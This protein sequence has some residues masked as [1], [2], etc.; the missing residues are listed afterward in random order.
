MASLSTPPETLAAAE[1]EEEEAGEAEE[2]EE[3]E[4]PRIG[5]LRSYA[6]NHTVDETIDLLTS[7]IGG[8]NFKPIVI[9]ESMC[10]SAP[11]VM[12][13]ILGEALFSVEDGKLSEQ[14][15]TKGGAY[16]KA[17]C[18]D[19]VDRQLATMCCMERYLVETDAV[20]DLRQVW[21]QLYE[22]EIVTDDATFARWFETPGLSRE[23][24]IDD[25][26]R[27]AT[28]EACKAFMQWLEN[29]DE[30]GADE[31]IDVAY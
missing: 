12:C 23:F 27:E 25:E 26:Q 28:R 10:F 16:F 3:E 1:G 2:E 14:L 6:S 21:N 13:F 15:K 17:L 5:K 19:K 8:G 18:G 4:D 20:K 9:G 11:N 30:D 29:P 31:D 24:G 22:L 7:K